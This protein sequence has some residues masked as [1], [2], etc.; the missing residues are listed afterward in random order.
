MLV[1][2]IQRFQKQ[3]LQFCL[4]DRS[5]R[6][7]IRHQ[8]RKSSLHSSLLC[9]S[10]DTIRVSQD[11]NSFYRSARLG[12]DTNPTE[13]RLLDGILEQKSQIRFPFS[14]DSSEV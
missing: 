12:K 2:I 9:A 1:C 4:S 14:Q 6:Q 5:R 7:F 3:S 8:Q 11:N 13:I 10:S